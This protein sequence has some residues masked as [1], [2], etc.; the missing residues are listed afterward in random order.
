MFHNCVSNGFGFCMTCRREGASLASPVTAPLKALRA[1]R[2]FV[3]ERAML[4]RSAFGLARD[5][6]GMGLATVASACDKLTPAL[7]SAETREA[8]APL[9][10]KLDTY[11]GEIV[12]A[13]EGARKRAEKAAEK[14]EKA[15]AERIAAQARLIALRASATL[16]VVAIRFAGGA[17]DLR[18]VA[19]GEPLPKGF[20]ESRACQRTRGAALGLRHRDAETVRDGVARKMATGSPLARRRRA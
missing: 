4:A 17:H 15:V 14:A 16:Y 13:S 1:R 3:R 19:V 18:I 9:I 8:L 5:A 20:R 10:S 12:R 11:K 6:G 7:A 2:A